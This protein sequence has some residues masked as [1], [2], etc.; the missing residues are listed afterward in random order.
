MRYSLNLLKHNSTFLKVF[1]GIENRVLF[2][3]S[4]H[5]SCFDFCN[6]FEIKLKMN[7]PCGV[8][9]F[10]SDVSID[11]LKHEDKH[12]DMLEQR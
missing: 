4:L 7:L 12:R 8:A 9:S 5:F 1:T 6:F 3:V 11:N 10:S 2:L